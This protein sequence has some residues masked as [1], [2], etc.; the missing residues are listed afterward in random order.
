M[1]YKTIAAV[2][3]PTILQQGHCVIDVRSP[4]EYRGA[5]VV[6]AEL[7]PLDKLN[8]T[9]FSQK[10]DTEAPVYILCQT[11]KRSRI[12]AE[13]LA[14][15][16]HRNLHV[17]EGGTDA[18]KAAGLEIEYGKGTISIERQVRIAAG[19]L[20]VIGVALGIFSHPGFLGI[21]A[22]VGCGLVFAGITDTC[23]MGLML[24]KMPWNR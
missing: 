16:G 12:A 9:T 24:A 20:V 18:A 19:T 2:E 13:K 11:G 10:H 17:V 8:T 6:G 5:H 1:T 22:F 7:Q 21:S 15:A 14:S 23:G 3:L 4:S